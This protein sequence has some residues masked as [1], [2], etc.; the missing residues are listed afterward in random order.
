MAL[1]AKPNFPRALFNRGTVLLKLASPEDAL[2]A[3]D[4]ALS[5]APAYSVALV[6]RGVALKEQGRFVEADAAFDAALAHEPN[7]AH[8]KNNKGAL[9]RL[10]GD[11]EHGWEGYENR[12][13]TGPTP[14]TKLQFPIPEWEGKCRAGEKLIVFDE[15]GFGDTSQFC[16]Y[17]PL[18]ATAGTDVT[19]FCRSSLLQLMRGLGPL[20]RCLDYLGPQEKFD[21]QIALLSLPRALATR[22]GSIPADVPYL[23]PEPELVAKWAER[24]GPG[25][26]F[27]IGLCWHGSPNL[28]AD[29]GR[30]MP[31]ACFAALARDGARLVS[32]QQRDGLDELATAPFDIESLGDDFDAGSDAFV[33]TAAVMQSLDMIV[34]C[35]TSV[36]HLA[37]ALG[38]PVF[39]MLKKIPDWRWL[40]DRDDNS[41]WY[42]T[43]RLFRQRERG[44]WRDVMARVSEVIE[45]VRE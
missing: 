26:D 27:K 12:W 42:S 35:D 10:R 28:R 16:R 7:S 5:L 43:M 1:A 34:T 17:L 2:A 20:V 37:G 29:P 22:L 11:L 3:F 30:S 39:V 13:I 24:L 8:P 9:D 15:Q 6:G 38:R 40:L 31:L 21:S 44:D 25:K 18:I 32:L 4:R 45:A 36:A 33:D 41:R 23:S 19:F 14:K